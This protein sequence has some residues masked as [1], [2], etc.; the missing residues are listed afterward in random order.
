MA[1]TFFRPQL[2]IASASCSE[3]PITARARRCS[4]VLKTN[5]PA[6]SAASRGY[7][8]VNI[9]TRS[10]PRAPWVRA[11]RRRVPPAG[12]WMES[13]MPR[14]SASASPGLRDQ[15]GAFLGSAAEAVAGRQGWRHPRQTVTLRRRG[16]GKACGSPGGEPSDD[17]ADPRESE[18]AEARR[19]EARGLAVL[20]D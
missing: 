5:R 2:R 4:T 12:R 13:A 18:L 7:D 17:V 3:Q 20:T 1:C 14:V 6:R 15:K 19:G 11:R 16:V 10:G 8:V 9:A